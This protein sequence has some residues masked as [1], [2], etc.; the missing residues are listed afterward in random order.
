MK[1]VLSDEFD[2]LDKTSYIP[3]LTRYVTHVIALQAVM[4]MHPQ[5]IYEMMLANAAF[6]S[7]KSNNG[8]LY[9]YNDHVRILDPHTTVCYITNNILYLTKKIH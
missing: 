4:L 7:D 2:E 8:Q 6:T 1:I 9:K 5:M 3:S